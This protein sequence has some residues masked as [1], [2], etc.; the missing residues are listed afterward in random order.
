MKNCYYFRKGSFIIDKK[1]GKVKRYGG[2]KMDFQHYIGKLRS[3]LSYKGFTAII[4]A[5][6]AIALTLIL[7][8]NV[9]PETYDFELFSVSEKTIRSPITI[10]DETQTDELKKIAAEEVE[11]AYVVKKEIMGNRISLVES[12]FD[13]AK[14]VSEE[15][16]IKDAKDDRENQ[17][18]PIEEQLTKL[19]TKLSENVS[20]NIT[21]V[22]PDDALKALLHASP[23]LLLDVKEKTTK[24]VEIVMGDK[25]REGQ[26]GKGREQYSQ[27]MNDE[28]ITEPLKNAA[29]Q[30]G[31]YAI[32]AN[33]ILDEDLTEERRQQAMQA[34]EPVRILQGQIVVQEGHL[35]DR[36]VYRQL[37]M[38][39][40][41]KSSPS[42]KPMV[43]LVIFVIMAVGSIYLYFSKV[44]Q[45]EEKKQNELILSS[46][47]LLFAL[48]F[49]K[50]IGFMEDLNV[51]YISYLFPAAM[52]PMLLKTL[53]NERFSLI[54]T[55]LLAACGSI[56]F[57][58]ELSNAINVEVAIYILLSGLASILF[59]HGKTSRTQFLKAGLFVSAVNIF[60]IL[61]I[62]FISG[63]QL[64]PIEYIVIGIIGVTSGMLSSVLTIGL[65]PFFEVGFG[66]LSTFQLI[67]LS[68][69]NQPLLKKV[70][71][72]TPG[73]Y[74]HSVM[75]ANLA[76]SACEAIG[77]NGL[78]ARVGCY[79][80]DVGK[81][82]RPQ[83]FIENQMNIQNPHD[84]LPP[85]KSKDIIIAH[86]TDGAELLRK[87][88]L[89]KAIVDIAE[90]HHG[91][92][93]LKFFYYKA[94]EQDDSI[95]E[96]DYR[97]PGPK[98]QTKET[99]IIS[100]ADSVEAAVRSKANPKPDEIRKLVHQIV[101]D[102]VQDGQ[103][104]ECDLSLKELEMIKKTLCET[105][106]GIF[107]SR[108]EYPDN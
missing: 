56:I 106:N 73:T 94:K 48:I 104:N 45:S 107:H 86:A 47:I 17:K 59:L 65:L 71:T 53:V 57:H 24:N 25:I 19:K 100:I 49:M 32:V 28:K 50:I 42:K 12:I 60:I 63:G 72:E 91:T 6:L 92:S 99:A 89:P 108:I 52:A 31:Q 33:E 85:E 21:D 96:E 81:T 78:L 29:L 64:R 105:L 22:I 70:L 4:Y 103:F 44:N 82:V 8:H 102:K 58:D 95:K 87:H 1:V 14:E 40:L 5:L 34:V 35:I 93:L 61:F 75:V 80:H 88:K 3:I 13:F 74:H 16:I 7:F 101:Q 20:E 39:G 79:Y 37:E 76:E 23:T 46:I 77:A 54:I 9:K 2:F 27:L 43:A 90:Q 30:I 26:V 55:I 66:M 38:L 97:Y 11:P 69:P 15:S 41:L 83:F 51:E 10:E 68:S 36:E 84:R 98:P 62:V 67:E 18:I